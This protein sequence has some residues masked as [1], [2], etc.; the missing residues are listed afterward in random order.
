MKHLDT[1]NTN[2]DKGGNEPK[3]R[4]RGRS[5]D[6]NQKLVIAI[7]GI[8][9]VIVLGI[10]GFMHSRQDKAAEEMAAAQESIAAE[11]AQ[12]A[13]AEGFETAELDVCNIP[14]LNILVDEYFK[15]RL[16]CD[17]DKLDEIFGRS[18]SDADTALA[19]R[20]KVQADW[21]QSYNV[22]DVYAAK[23][24]DDN[25]RI[26]LVFYDIDF[27]RTDTLA[28]GVMYFY[29]V[30]DESG[31]YTVMENPVKEIHDYIQ[32]ELAS[33][34]AVQLINDSNARLKEALDSDSTLA[35]IYESFRSG[36]I[37]RETDIDINADQEVGL[38]TD[39]EDSVLVDQDVL[40]EIQNEAAED[41][42]IEASLA[43]EDESSQASADE[44][45]AA[46]SE[47]SSE[48]VQ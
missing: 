8:A 16:A 21:I 29:A 18:K 22:T 48:N 5:E 20:L 4:S 41:A 1:L 14:E 38:F 24:L 7:G 25:A 19:E 39:P 10:A 42:S 34:R 11:A 37:Y 32:A 9:A 15:A 3:K 30:R 6:K 23:G 27:R 45:T 44:E 35:L 40:N 12:A 46:E 36:E 43:A 13:S 28:P 31:T 47:P 26:C 17:T 33:D 2:P